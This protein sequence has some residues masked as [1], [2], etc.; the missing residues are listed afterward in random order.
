MTS[1]RLTPVGNG[2]GVPEGVGEG[3]GVRVALGVA[4]G[5]GVGVPPSVLDRPGEGR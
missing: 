4:V 5:L 3:V 2:C 1:F